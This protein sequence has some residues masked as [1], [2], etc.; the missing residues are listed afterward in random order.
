M[1]QLNNKNFN[2]SSFIKIH[3]VLSGTLSPFALQ[4]FSAVGQNYCQPLTCY[5]LISSTKLK[6]IL[7]TYLDFSDVLPAAPS[8]L[9]KLVV[10]ALCTDAESEVGL[11]EPLAV[12]M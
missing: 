3:K 4:K 10:S 9:F 6:T 5:T 11:L 12:P 7:S 2:H 8:Q 1:Q